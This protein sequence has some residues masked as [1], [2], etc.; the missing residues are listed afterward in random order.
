MLSAFALGEADNVTLYADEVV[1][2]MPF[3]DTLE[4]QYIALSSLSQSG[5]R[6]ECLAKGIEI[7]RQLGFNIPSALAR[8]SVIVAMA[9]A[10]NVASQYNADQ[11]ISLCDMNIDNTVTRVVRIMDA[12]HRSSFALS[13]PYCKSY[14]ICLYFGFLCIC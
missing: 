2:H 12:F 11:I 8:Q 14:M 10:N 6:Q 5:K 13:S 3:E 1:K 9:S 4:T 7:L